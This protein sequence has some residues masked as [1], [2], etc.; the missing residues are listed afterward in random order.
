MRLL[1]LLVLGFT[2]F[3]ADAR[4]A[5]VCDEVCNTADGG[6]CSNC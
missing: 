6:N 3:T 4:A 2:L 5:F 1:A